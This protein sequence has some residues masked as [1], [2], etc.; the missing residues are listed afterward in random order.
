MYEGHSWN[1]NRLLV[2][3]S[4]HDT[5]HVDAL[6]FDGNHERLDSLALDL[7][8]DE[9]GNRSVRTA[10]D[11]QSGRW[12]GA[13]VDNEV[14]VFRIG[15]NDL[16]GPRLLG[17]HEGS[18]IRI[19]FDP[20]GRYLATVSQEGEIR[21]WDPTGASPP[22]IF[23]GLELNWYPFASW[24]FRFTR[25]GSMLEVLFV[26]DEQLKLWLWSVTGGEPR[27][28]RRFGLGEDGPAAWEQIDPVGGHLARVDWDRKV[29][30][31]P[32][33][34][35]A[36][37][38]PL[39]VGRNETGQLWRP[40]FD[41]Q[42]YW[43]ATGSASGL[44]LYPLGRLYP[45]VMRHDAKSIFKVVFAPDGSWFASAE[46]YEGVRIWPLEGEVPPAGR[47][48]AEDTLC[49]LAVSPD[50]QHVL[51]ANQKRNVEGDVL[52][53]VFRGSRRVLTGFRGQTSGVAFSP[54][55][56]LAAGA[57]G[58]FD[59][60]ENVIRVWDVASGHELT[61]LVPEADLY[62]WALQFTADDRLLSSGQ[63]G[64]RR[65]NVE[66]GESELLYEGMVKEFSASGDGRRVLLVEV[67]EWSNPVGGRAVVV[68]LDNAFATPLETHGNRVTAVALDTAGTIAA[69]GD[70]D[71]VIR[72]GPVTGEEP[73]VLLGHETRVY[74]LAFD[75]LG[76]WIAS[77]GNDGTARLWPMP[78]LSEP[79]LHTLPREELI[80]RLK[81]LTNIR[82]VRD[83]GTAIGWK[84]SHDPF[85]GWETVPTW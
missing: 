38:E 35:P 49:N 44:A 51:V 9:D 56:R 55:G 64:L 67:D 37:A 46:P 27:L 83:E 63:D 45:S 28:L 15:E 22:R 76:R 72:L 41:H 20:F 19:T 3:V 36:D 71:G 85:P 78:D 26:E 30:I 23:E 2:L 69:T 33:R 7:R 82:V 62:E 60:N 54:D 74:D 59:G 68:E 11:R 42:G 58:T 21:I 47:S 80:A 73:H 31:W 48:L 1:E 77:G 17:R 43:L 8:R 70:V 4:E 50:G 32:F 75:P 53:P 61:V 5:T 52:I 29:R 14:L 12:L 66:T 10:M 65:W 84:L 13:V 6:Y 16:V 57:G 40:V 79:P 24:D 25:D 81:T 34:T 39:I 18:D